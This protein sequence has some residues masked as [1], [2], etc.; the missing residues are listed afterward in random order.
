MENH[1]VGLGGRAG[2][3][4]LVREADRSQAVGRHRLD[5]VA[6]EAVSVLEIAKIR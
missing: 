5:D 3:V 4:V 1:F 2:H 6:H